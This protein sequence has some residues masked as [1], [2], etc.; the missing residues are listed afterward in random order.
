MTDT[1]STTAAP[2]PAAGGPATVPAREATV[3]P[4]SPD[5][6]E[7]EGGGRESRDT[8]WELLRLVRPVYGRLALAV[9]S[10]ALATVAGLVPFVAVAELGRALYQGDSTRAWLAAGV[11]V[12]A[13]L[14]RAVLLALATMLAHLADNDLQHQLRR[15]LVHHA[16]RLP[17]GR[18][19]G[20]GAGALKK[21]VSDDVSALHHVIGHALLDLVASVVA[22]VAALVYLFTVDPAMTLITLLPVTAGLLLHRRALSLATGRM[23]EYHA[24][25]GQLNSAGVEFVRGIAVVKT[26]G[27]AGE[28]HHSF[29]EAAARYAAFVADWAR[30]VTRC[31]A[32]SQI[33]LSPPAVLLTVLLGGTALIQS[34][35]L[36]P[37]DLLP[38]LLLGLA[39]TAPV[40]A[41]GY[42][43]QDLRTAQSAAARLRD[44]FAEPPLPEPSRP[45]L[46][47]GARVEF[48]G[49]RFSYDGR[50][51]V[52][53]GIDLTLEPGT[54][55]ALVG[56]S[57]AG[58]STLATLPAR[59]HDVTAGA[60][61]IGGADVRDIP[62][63]ELY[64]QVGFVFQDTRLRRGSVRDNIRLGRPDASDAEIESAARA[65]RIHDRITALPHGYDTVL[66]DG[67]ALS[68]G[69]AQR[70][71]LARALLA[72]RP[73][74]V[75]DEA[76]AATDPESEAA[77][78]E[79]LAT[80]LTGRT[81]LV[82]AHRLATI[83]HA[84][85]IVVLDRGRLVEAGR[86]TELLARN[87]RYAAL[88]RAQRGRDTAV[89]LL[90]GEEVP[91]TAPGD[92]RREPQ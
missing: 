80:L 50:T 83:V 16:G 57:G 20:G 60:V 70:V 25:V 89:P 26:F 64:R 88:W 78:H 52:L 33:A 79:A 55:T 66:G 9:T 75:L 56:S 51:D 87:G 59:F 38:F 85:R 5:T 12:A 43:T 6:P 30:S 44:M 2:D 53:H 28:A 39:L 77:I 11:G 46:P 36:D 72:D 18:L 1:R 86:H 68:G 35:R 58:K 63:A 48:D 37:P 76:T 29:R 81:V 8:S 62:V 4:D 32:G 22:P 40:L 41:L 14:V 73:V 92:D 49:V 23:T 42:A 17:L 3:P 67:T 47:T 71:T 90:P 15:R 45:R 91:G 27:R 31:T 34:G 10:Q 74:L 69:E 82:V 61:R 54:V 19:G 21:A 24:A 84:D 65:A 13:L 7:R